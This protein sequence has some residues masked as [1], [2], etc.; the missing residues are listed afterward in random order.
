VAKLRHS[1]LPSEIAGTWLRN[2]IFHHGQNAFAFA[3]TRTLRLFRYFFSHGTIGV[4]G[5]LLFAFALA[6]LLWRSRIHNEKHD[7]SLA[8]LLLLPFLITLAMSIAGLYPY[9]GT[10]HD[11]VLALFAL[12]G[13][14]IGLDRLPLGRG[15]SAMFAKS[16]CLLT[17]LIIC[18][19]FASP[20]GPYIAPL[21]QERNRMQ[22][23]LAF[24]RSLPAGS[25]ILTDQQGSMALNYYLCDEKMPLAFF[26]QS[27][28]LLRLQCGEYFVIT[29]AN[30][31]TGFD[32]GAFPA[33]LKEV[34]MDGQPASVYLFQSG[35]INDKEEVW[36]DE[37]RE[38]G[39][40]PRNFGPNILVCRFNRPALSGQEP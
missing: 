24:L 7:R 18:N 29:A 32:R 21:D 9:G 3:W 33:L 13:V 16:V 27:Q 14:A 38:L 40:S 20:S 36:L 30:T 12:P 26:Q 2:S 28:P 1:G 17:A 25:S 34:W 23:A 15:K 39:G 8:L 31:Q 6:A 37:L 10:R 35:W 5:F 4:L 19:A 11:V 22:Q